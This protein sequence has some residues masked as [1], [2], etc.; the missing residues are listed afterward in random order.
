MPEK[1]R[2]EHSR[3]A[4]SSYRKT[5]MSR[6]E[7]RDWVA[8]T[9]ARQGL[10][11]TI[12]DPGTLAKV[13]MLVADTMTVATVMQRESTARR[14]PSNAP[15]GSQLGAGVEDLATAPNRLHRH[16]VERQ[17]EHGLASL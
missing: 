7:L 12:N 11:P 1:V 10:R 5:T 17:P 4:S 13:A 9:R 3:S 8:E 16:A 15:V 2:S 14:V 6:Q